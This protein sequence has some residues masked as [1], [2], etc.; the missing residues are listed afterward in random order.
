MFQAYYELNELSDYS[1]SEI[2][3]I[4]SLEAFCLFAGGIFVGPIHDARGPRW[5]L[6]GGTFVSLDLVPH[7]ARGASC[8]LTV[9]ALPLL[10]SFQVDNLTCVC[11]CTSLAS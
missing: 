8:S 2:A 4:T 7:I 11:R 6:V 1:H 9:T 3:W 5:L 10:N